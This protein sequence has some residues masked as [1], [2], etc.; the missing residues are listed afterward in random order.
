MLTLNTPESF[1]NS[2]NVSVLSSFLNTS[3][4]RTEN[5]ILENS[6][7][8][9]NYDMESLETNMIAKGINTSN[10]LSTLDSLIKDSNEYIY[11]DFYEIFNPELIFTIYQNNIQGYLEVNFSSD[12]TDYIYEEYGCIYKNLNLAIDSTED[13]I[14]VFLA[15]EYNYNYDDVDDEI[16]IEQIKIEEKNNTSDKV[17]ERFIVND[18]NLNFDQFSKKFASCFNLK[19]IWL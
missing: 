7:E 4:G 9:E 13:E 6:L 12:S 19:D 10:L 17:W 5:E 18:K 8:L 15:R 3:L 2:E 14:S 16:I 1:D 11:C